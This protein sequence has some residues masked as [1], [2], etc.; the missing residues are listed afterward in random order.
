MQT[1]KFFRFALQKLG[2]DDG[3]AD[4]A[5]IRVVVDDKSDSK[6]LLGAKASITEIMSRPSLALSTANIAATMPKP[7]RREHLVQRY[8]NK[9]S[10]LVQ[11][12]RRDTSKKTDRT[13]SAAS[14]SPSSTIPTTP[15][16]AVSSDGT[17]DADATPAGPTVDQT[18]T[19]TIRPGGSTPPVEAIRA[20]S[21][22]SNALPDSPSAVSF[23]G[24]MTSEPI[25]ERTYDSDSD[26]S[27]ASSATSVG[28]EDTDADYFNIFKDDDW[29]LDAEPTS[30]SAKDPVG[31][32]N[33]SNTEEETIFDGEDIA[34]SPVAE[35]T[36]A[37]D[38][39]PSADITATDTHTAPTSRES[40]IHVYEDDFWAPPCPTRTLDEIYEDAGFEHHWWH[41]HEEVGF[42]TADGGVE[43][44][45]CGCAHGAFCHLFNP[46]AEKNK[47]QAAYWEAKGE[48]LGH[49]CTWQL[50]DSPDPF[51]AAADRAKGLPELVVTTP[52]GEKKYLSDMTYR[53]GETNWADLDDD[54]D[55]I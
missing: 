16:S 4:I 55:W 2:I 22:E 53:A 35:P 38:E 21:T 41:F 51:A 10:S 39:G 49:K 36:E 6:Q 1:V 47:R 52:E 28:T 45:N 34:S 26:E 40:F 3:V 50:L 44:S 31:E 33:E 13:A 29:N 24:T 7:V 8:W 11:N 20:Y 19:I 54:E 18:L 46:I 15:C 5:Q 27:S 48:P 42:Q 43:V 23:S 30:P 25:T 12:R 9:I 32:D 17:S 14:A 37:A